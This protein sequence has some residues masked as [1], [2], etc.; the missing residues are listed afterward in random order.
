MSLQVTAYVRTN[1]WWFYKYGNLINESNVTVYDLITMN[2]ISSS[3][4]FKMDFT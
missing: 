4:Q 3:L 2:F 1:G